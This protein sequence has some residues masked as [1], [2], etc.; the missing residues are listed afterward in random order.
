MTSLFEELKLYP[1]YTNSLSWLKWYA[2]ILPFKAKRTLKILR[3]YKD[4]NSILLDFGCSIGLTLGFLAPYFK[5]VYAYDIDQQAIA[6]AKK[7][8]QQKGLK[9]VFI[10]GKNNKIP[11][12]TNSVDIVTAIEVYEHLD[13]PLKAL[14]EIH[15]VLKP[16]GILHITTANKLWPLEPHFHL[17]FLS[18]LPS[19]L[20]NY[21]VRITKRGKSYQGINLPTYFQ[22]YQTV[23]HYF[24]I[25]D[26]TLKVITDY[27]DYGLDR[28]RGK[29]IIYIAK[30]IKFL[31]KLNLDKFL[32]NFSLGWLFICRKKPLLLPAAGRKNP[33]KNK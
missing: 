1:Q 11:L 15:R 33:G 17:P 16:S 6:V 32:L 27:H 21:Y 25:E 9:A 18:Y 10:L 5:K 29:K 23:N 7:R 24:S 26:T 14:K 31:Q 28:E 22:F 4:K 3:K 8:F 13:K 2:K 19:K 20:A 12:P 30:L